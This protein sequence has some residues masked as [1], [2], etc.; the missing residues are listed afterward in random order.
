MKQSLADELREVLSDQDK[1]VVD[2]LMEN[3]KR[4]IAEVDHLARN[5]SVKVAGRGKTS[6]AGRAPW[7]LGAIA[8]SAAAIVVV[9]TQINHVGDIA[10]T[11][12]PPTATVPQRIKQTTT[13][14][15]SS[16]TD[17]RAAAPAGRQVSAAT[18]A[19][20]VILEREAEQQFVD[21]LADAMTDEATWSVTSDDVDKIIEESTNEDGI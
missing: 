10:V 1:Q 19:V 15:A 5:T 2:L 21:M 14:E 17:T 6:D 4:H 3:K 16:A 9:F 18:L 12:G 8:A 20:D 7:L 13:G 11:T